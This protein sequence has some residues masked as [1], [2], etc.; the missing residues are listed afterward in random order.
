MTTARQL[1]AYLQ[2]IPED[3]KITVL[4]KDRD[5]KQETYY[6][7]LSLN[8]SKMFYTGGVVGSELYLIGERC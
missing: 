8:E 4:H 3:T 5:N 1:I 2:T 7:D 6:K